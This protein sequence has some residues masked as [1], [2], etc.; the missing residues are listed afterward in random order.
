MNH[1]MSGVFSDVDLL[2]LKTDLPP[3][4]NMQTQRIN[5]I[6]QPLIV[7]GR[8]N[9]KERDP[10]E[11][12]LK[13]EPNEIEL[14]DGDASEENTAMPAINAYDTC[15]RN[16]NSALISNYANSPSEHGTATYKTLDFEAGINTSLRIFV[17]KFDEIAQNINRILI[18]LSDKSPC[19]TKNQ[20]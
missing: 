19:E 1:A 10:N 7:V 5:N 14:N 6:K 11:N 13:T 17:R 20:Q 9:S 4:I 8:V 12:G 18:N 15:K 2:L 3:Q 16:N